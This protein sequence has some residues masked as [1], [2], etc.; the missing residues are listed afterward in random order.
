MGLHFIGSRLV[1]VL[2]DKGTVVR[3]VENLSSG[4]T[5]SIQDHLGLGRKFLN[6]DLNDPEIISG[7]MN[8]IQT[9][10]HLAAIMAAADTLT[11]TRWSVRRI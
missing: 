5:D 7:A 6:Q 3:V 11:L 1:G 4:K 2:V 10:F 8:G 9:V